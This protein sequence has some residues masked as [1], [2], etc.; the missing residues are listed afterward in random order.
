MADTGRVS[1]PGVC[2]GEEEGLGWE[3]GW[4]RGG[5]VQMDFSPRINHCRHRNEPT[6]VMDGWNFCVD[7]FSIADNLVVLAFPLFLCMCVAKHIPT[8]ARRHGC[9][10]LFHTCCLKSF[11]RQLLRLKKEKLGSKNP[12]IA[13]NFFTLFVSLNLSK[14]SLQV[15][16]ETFTS[17]GVCTHGGH[18]APG[19]PV[20][21][22]PLIGWDDVM[23]LGDGHT[24][25]T[26][27]AVSVAAL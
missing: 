15:A 7:V 11:S 22:D 4:G 18:M 24:P 6:A 3:R 16:R 23:W 12:P 25:F 10:L 13:S 19:A 17:A 21:A 26:V 2:W 1:V 9:S 5:S 8:P 14:E 20:H 27:M